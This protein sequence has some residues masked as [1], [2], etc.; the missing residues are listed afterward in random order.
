MVPWKYH[1]GVILNFKSAVTT[2]FFLD[3]PNA[4]ESIS[5][6]S[7]CL[8]IPFLSLQCG[9]A[10]VRDEWWKVVTRLLLQFDC[11]SGSS[12]NDFLF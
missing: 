4:L 6:P 10:P 8:G 9:K 3:M 2:T 7:L 11:P 12:G 1:I 5:P